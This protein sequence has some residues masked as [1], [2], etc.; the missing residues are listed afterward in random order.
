MN[1]TVKWIVGITAG[2]LAAS[3]LYAYHKVGSS[4][5]AE[6]AAVSTGEPSAP[7]AVP[8]AVADPE[9]SEF[10][11]Q[12]GITAFVRDCRRPTLDEWKACQ[13]DSSDVNLICDRPTWSGDGFTDVKAGR[14]NLCACH[15]ERPA[16]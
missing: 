2:V 6:D 1:N 9:A 12:C 4:S 7:V 14:V 16:N 13:E 11:R 10:T 5:V 15:T 8:K 3:V